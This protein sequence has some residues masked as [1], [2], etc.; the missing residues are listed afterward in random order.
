MNTI[1]MIRQFYA[2]N[3]WANEREL[4]SLKESNSA[5]AARYFYHILLAEKF[6][7][8]RILENADTTGYNFWHDATVEEC[9]KLLNEN[10]DSYNAFFA[11]LT[12]EKL[13][14]TATYK[15]SKG[16]QYTSTYRE[17]FTH[18]FFHSAYH[19]G[20][21]TTALR[22]DGAI[23]PYTDFIGFLRDIK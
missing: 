13:D 20:Q 4:A 18:V 5:S 9:E 16:V 11:D 15:N 2:Y 17:I 7:L 1:E 22:T 21:I 23:P 6:W 12:E 10:K 14:E 3:T 19:R 8:K